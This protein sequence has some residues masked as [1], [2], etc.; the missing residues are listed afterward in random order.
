MPDSYDHLS[1][2]VDHLEWA[3]ERVLQSLRAARAPLPAAISLFSHVLGAEHTW[4]NRISGELPRVAVWPEL[5]FQQCAQ[6]A[7]ENADTLRGLVA[8]LGGDDGM[9]QITYRNSSGAEFTT[10]LEDI[11][12]HV[13]MHGAY[14][15]GQ[16]A[17]LL[18]SAGDEPS[19]T[20]FIQWVRRAAT[21]TR[22]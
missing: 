22:A 21:A 4:L 3:D 16:V 14:H 1:R 13:A 12:L 10:G 15:R 6:L 9:R 5:S 17:A 8:S 18:R 20:D 2:L 11:L 7:A 19:P